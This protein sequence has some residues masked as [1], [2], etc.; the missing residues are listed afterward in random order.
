VISAKA[1]GAAPCAA[2]SG[3]PAEE[4]SKPDNGAGSVDEP[5]APAG[6][7]CIYPQLIA[8]GISSIRSEAF[9]FDKSKYGFLVGW[10]TT[11]GDT[12]FRG[13]WAYTAP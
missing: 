13:V 9:P 10:N 6:T 7:V 2:R 5:S 1:N 12:L 4:K 11:T 3:F 8:G